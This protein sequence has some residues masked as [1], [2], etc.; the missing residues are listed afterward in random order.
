MSD[1]LDNREKS[2]NQDEEIPTA[3]KVKPQTYN[4][5]NTGVPQVSDRPDAF[6]EWENGDPIAEIGDE[7]V[8]RSDHE[9][10]MLKQ[11]L[12]CFNKGQERERERIT[13]QIK[14]RMDELEEQIKFTKEKEA[15]YNLS[16]QTSKVDEGDNAKLNLLEELLDEVQNE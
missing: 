7:L 8:R 1:S 5:P 13:E 3:A 11:G 10:E 9:H 15:E 2:I 12:I 14:E 6:L 4:H 16:G